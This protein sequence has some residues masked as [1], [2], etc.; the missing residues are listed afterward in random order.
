MEGGKRRGDASRLQAWKKVG[1][2]G[3]CILHKF[4]K[5]GRGQTKWVRKYT[6]KTTKKEGGGR[7]EKEN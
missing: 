7:G 3:E 5:E 6:T 2:R 1:S 4:K